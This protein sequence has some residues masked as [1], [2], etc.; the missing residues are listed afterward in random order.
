MTPD[1]DDLRAAHKNALDVYLKAVT[2]K[3]LA[4]QK[5]IGS[6]ATQDADAYAAKAQ[7]EGQRHGEYL[8][9]VKQLGPA[10]RGQKG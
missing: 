10:L 7:I 3:N 2:A 4:L 8:D 6:G 5:Y 9:L 1:I